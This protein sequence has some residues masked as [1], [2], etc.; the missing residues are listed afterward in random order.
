M[1]NDSVTIAKITAA[2]NIVQAFAA[3]GGAAAKDVFEAARD[4]L[5]EQF[6]DGEAV[7]KKKA[8]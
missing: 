2:Q 3:N 6:K 4:F 5:I 1:T 7:A 8:A